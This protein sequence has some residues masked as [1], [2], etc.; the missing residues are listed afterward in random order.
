MRVRRGVGLALAALVCAVPAFAGGGAEQPKTASVKV[1]IVVKDSDDAWQAVQQG[2]LAAADGL[3]GVEVDYEVPSNATADAQARI[4]ADLVAQRV[5][6]I[7]I[8]P[9]EGS[10][11]LVAAVK[12]AVDAHIA[13]ITFDGRLAPGGPLLEVSS[14]SAGVVGGALVTMLAGQIGDSGEI[15]ILSG[16]PD[17]AY[18]AAVIEGMTSGL[19]PHPNVRLVAILYGNDRA[20]VSARE[21]AV[22]LKA[23]PGVK[24]IIALTPVGLEA[25][26]TALKDADLG[27]KVKLTGIGVPGGMQSAFD[28]GTCTQM[29]LGVPFDIGYAATYVAARLGRGQVKG[30]RGETIMAGGLGPLMVDD[31]LNAPIVQPTVVTPETIASFVQP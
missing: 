7:A 28:D 12:K 15:G 21:T 4:V 19:G 24:G 3:G 31:S 11:A 8:S 20:D 9:D 22:M 23:Y 27:G 10:S 6:A 14:A 1:A 25:A 26:A 17:S 18:L 16:S 2:A 29:L 30:S 13:V 5:N